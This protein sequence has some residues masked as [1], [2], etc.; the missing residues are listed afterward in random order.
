MRS[1]AGTQRDI[2]LGDGAPDSVPKLTSIELFQTLTKVILAWSLLRTLEWDNN[3]DEVVYF[4][5][6]LYVQQQMKSGIKRSKYTR[7]L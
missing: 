5:A 7:P 6:F 2:L 3:L 1:F 4:A